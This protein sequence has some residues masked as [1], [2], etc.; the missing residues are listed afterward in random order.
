M[1]R[2]L[3][4]G[5]GKRGEGGYLRVYPQTHLTSDAHHHLPK[6]CVMSRRNASQ[7]T[8]AATSNRPNRPCNCNCNCNC[9]C[10]CKC[11]D[12]NHIDK[13]LYTTTIRN[14]LFEK[15]KKTKRLT[16]KKRTQ[17]LTPE[18]KLFGSNR[19]SPK[20]SGLISPPSLQMD[21]KVVIGSYMCLPERGSLLFSAAVL[22]CWLV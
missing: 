7:G 16:P 13:N 4:R 5:N 20:N 17:R 14:V 6:A 18:N 8:S 19:F 10:K 15:P 9:K 21:A 3:C 11:I 22:W 12:K 1:P 2:W